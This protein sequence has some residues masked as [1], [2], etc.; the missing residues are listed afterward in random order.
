LFVSLYPL[1]GKIDILG[2]AG[3]RLE[4]NF[5]LS[6]DVWAAFDEPPSTLT[7]IS[8][9]KKENKYLFIWVRTSTQFSRKQTCN[10]GYCMISIAIINQIPYKQYKFEKAEIQRRMM[11][12]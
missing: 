6:L 7:S 11:H 12:E 2:N 10:V 4:S 8:E 5:E 9:N 3:P 1:I